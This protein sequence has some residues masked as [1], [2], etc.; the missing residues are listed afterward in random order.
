MKGGLSLNFLKVRFRTL[1]SI[2][3]LYVGKI[4]G[5]LTVFFFLPQYASL[6]GG[7]RFGVAVVIIS[8]IGFFVAFDLGMSTFIGREVS[9][10]VLENHGI[11]KLIYTAETS[12]SVMYCLLM[13]LGVLVHFYAGLAGLN[14]WLVPFIFLLFWVITLQNMHYSVMIASG[15]FTKASIIQMF[16][17]ILRALGT[18][19]VLYYLS[20]SVEAFV[21]SQLAIATVHLVLT[22]H[23]SLKKFQVKEPLSWRYHVSGVDCL[24]L[25]KKTSGLAV[26]AI[27]GAAVMQLDKPLIGVFVS[28]ESV[29][30]YFFAT[31][32]CLLPISI[33]A[34]PVAQYFQPLLINS[35][36]L[37]EGNGSS[38]VLRKFTLVLLLVT[39]L[40]TMLFWFFRVTVIELWLGHAS[41]ISQVSAY[42]Q[43]L[44]IGIAI[45]A[46]G[47]IPFTLLLSN[48]DFRFQAR[49]SFIATI[50]TLLVT[51]H[52][53]YT[54]N[55]MGIC[56]VYAVY[57]FVVSL[58]WWLRAFA[59]GES[60]FLAKQ[61]ALLV[62]R[63]IMILALIYIMTLI[64]KSL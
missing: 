27:S 28:P 20:T 14:A 54:K 26:L 13:V 11:K 41:N 4:A 15:D 60:R 10:G 48:G 25:L 3:M 29:V 52:F 50:A 57:H 51:T 19:I 63:V 9:A 34:S 46:L 56:Y 58:V 30:P 36:T 7:G 49:T 16:L 47:Y 61:S 40:P 55:I 33:L 32:A 12:I 53:A 6:M 39:A 17:T 62:A 22:R 38:L 18:F 24:L 35:M 37:K 42:I 1:L 59:L 44:L 5:V 21:F 45:G 31:T 2:G 23:Y 64:V 8:G 43:V